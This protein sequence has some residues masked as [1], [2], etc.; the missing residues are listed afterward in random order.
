MGDTA[1]FVRSLAG[2][3]MGLVLCNGV[4]IL[5]LW[6]RN[7]NPLYR[8][9]L[10][11]WAAG[12]LG[13]GAQ[14]VLVQTPYLIALG[15]AAG[16]PTNLALAHVV[17]LATGVALP[18]KRLVAILLSSIV[19]STGVAVLGGEFTAIALPIAI[20]VALPSLLT[21]LRVVRS[22]WQTL[23]ISTKA[24]VISAIAFSFHNLDF[25]FLRHRPEFVIFGFTI[26]ILIVFALSLTSLATAAR[27][28]HRTR[29]ARRPRDR[30]RSA[31]SDQDPAARL[32]ASRPGG[33]DLS[34]AG[35]IRRR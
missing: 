2:L 25:A 1:A 20:A 15:F 24:L 19:V 33:R 16:F 3:Y 14:A 22:K 27:A 28:R 29:G 11:V 9:L 17:V 23:R 6:W 10:W 21:A 7:K 12:A 26:A 31:H 35:R 13:L 5:T 8:A 32:R 34:Q 18:W 4:L 30:H